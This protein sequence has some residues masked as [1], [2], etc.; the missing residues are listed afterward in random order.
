M[1]V[2]RAGRARCAG[3]AWT[4]L[5]GARACER[6]WLRSRRT[7]RV[8]RATDLGLAGECARSES[9][10]RVCDPPRPRRRSP[11][12]AVPRRDSRA[13]RGAGR[14]GRGHAQVHQPGAAHPGRPGHVDRHGDQHHQRADPPGPGLRLAQPG[15]DH[16]PGGLRPGTHLG[17]Q[18]PDR[19]PRGRR[20][21]EPVRGDRPVP[22]SRRDPRL[23]ADRPGHAARAVP[24]R[25]RLPDGRARPA[26]Q[27]SRCRRPGPG[28]RPRR[29][30]AADRAAADDLAGHLHLAA[31]P[32][33]H[34]RTGRRP[35]GP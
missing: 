20:L 30:Y 19:P 12:G 17:V 21:P 1:A 14:A 5:A 22:G 6:G 4:G 24:D 23:H 2:E 10:P 3:G 18:R 13:R 26:E 9:G 29:R 15:P 16:R 27:R 28:V 25:R 33:P 11:A 32:G 31:V 34:R 35:P 7:E 8:Q